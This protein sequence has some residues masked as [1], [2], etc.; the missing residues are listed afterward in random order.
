M[1]HAR[2]RSGAR[3]RGWRIVLRW[4]QVSVLAG[5]TLAGTISPSIAEVR[6]TSLNPISPWVV[7]WAD[8][9]C[10][11]AR[12]FGTAQ[13][14]MLLTM[15]AYG[16]GYRF[17]IALAGDDVGFLRTAHGVT[18]AYGTGEPYPIG[19]RQQGGN[20]D[21]G[22]AIIFS[23]VLGDGEQDKTEPEPARAYPDPKFE[24]QADRISVGTSTRQVVLETHAMAPAF[25]KMRECTD[26]LVRKWG[27]D[28]AVESSLSR[29]VRMA[30]YGW[31]RKVQMVF[32][33]ELAF[34]GKQA[35]MNMR[36][37]VDRSGA[38]TGCDTAQAFSNT[39]FKER[40]CDIVL[41]NARFYPA[42]DKA[43]QP[44]NSFYSAIVVY[45]VR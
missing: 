32:P 36:I 20:T 18:I 2:L 28:P 4:F 40:A 15:R 42:L 23:H 34:Q 33:P 11:L 19:A 27:L 31:V 44:V 24:A 45:K 12:K 10:Q 41:R 17:E 14:P 16:P 8:D 35:R 6:Q 38:P 13:K 1:S 37:M 5:L 26:N 9:R 39:D 43:G 30:D 7:D 21:Y 29:R 3:S 22:P 25:G